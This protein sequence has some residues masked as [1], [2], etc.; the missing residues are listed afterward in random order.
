MFSLEI[1]SAFSAFAVFV[2]LVKWRTRL[3]ASGTPGARSPPGPKGYPIIGNVWD[4]P[5]ERAWLTYAEWAER[6]KSDVVQF[7]VF[8]TRTVILNSLKAATE[9]LD[10][11][12]SIY[13]DRPRMVRRFSSFP[14]LMNSICLK[15]GLRCFR[16]WLR[17][18]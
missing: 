7:T 16:L 6:Y 12:S 5:R 1:F 13:S 3:T 9:L 14:L 18:S 11:R 10:K 8:G 17:R 15:R 2:F 4:I